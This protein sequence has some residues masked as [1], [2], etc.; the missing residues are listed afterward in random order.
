M[1]T[2]AEI[3]ALSDSK[4]KAAE[5]LLA[6]GLV[7]DAYY[8]GG[9]SIELLLKAKICKT[10]CVP[11]FF[12]FSSKGGVKPETYKPFK[13]HDYEQLLLLSGL[14]E[15]LSN[16]KTTDETFQS[17][18]SLICNWGENFRYSTGTSS[19]DVKIFIDALKRMAKWLKTKI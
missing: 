6:N 5:I 10:L 17:D 8:L 15:E 11:D 13:T 16:Q 19:S 7:D 14:Y 2:E 12:T 1:K 3:I 4:L 18:W 9:Y